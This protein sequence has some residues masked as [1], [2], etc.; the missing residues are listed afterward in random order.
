[1]IFFSLL[2][3]SANLG[4]KDEAGRVVLGADRLLPACYM[5][6]YHHTIPNFMRFPLAITLNNCSI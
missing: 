3:S 4:H 6:P 2:T 1:M 5:V